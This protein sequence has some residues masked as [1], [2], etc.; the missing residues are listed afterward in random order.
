[1][2]AIRVHEFGPPEVMR[3]E[4]IPAPTA[5]PGQVVVRVHAAGIN[6]VDTYIRAGLYPDKPALPFTPGIDAA[7]IVESV[8]GRVSQVKVG[9]RVYAAGTVTGAYAE[10]AVCEGFH[11]HPL[12]KHVTFAQGAGINV[13]YATAYRALF[14]SARAVP[15]EVVL[16]HGA[17][18][19]VGIAAV[20]LAC[21][22]GMTVIGTAGSDRGRKLVKEQGAQH[23]LDHHAAD[24]LAQAVKLTKGRGVDVILEMLA[25]VNLNKDLGILAH[26]GR[27]V[28]IGSR[29]KIEIDPRETM[30][31]DASIIGML[32]MNVSERE[33][34]T[35][36][37]ALVTG[38]EKG[39]LRPIVGKEIPLADAPRAHEMVMEPGAYGKIVLIP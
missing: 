27:I 38:L 35:I 34:T 28:V 20:Q 1:M 11:V 39:K 29:G 26:G 15:G 16:V 9:D 7:G 21:T 12:P 6:P 33:A 8:G 17:S 32:L 31:R 36:H 24:Y 19:G 2:K 13:P 5:G 3:L 37:A 18:G 30:I 23:V 22:A 10:R 25:N 14:G 4:E